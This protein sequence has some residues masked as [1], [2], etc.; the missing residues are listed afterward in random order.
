MDDIGHENEMDD[1]EREVR[2]KVENKDEWPFYMFVRITSFA[3]GIWMG[4]G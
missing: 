2:T 3:T 4:H 1:S